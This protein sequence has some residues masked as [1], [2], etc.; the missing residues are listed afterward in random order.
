MLKPVQIFVEEDTL[1]W[2]AIQAIK[3]KTNRQKFLTI[4]I[5]SIKTYTHTGK[6][7]L[8]GDT[9]E[10][11]FTYNPPLKEMLKDILPSDKTK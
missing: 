5:E 3:R 6:F 8:N 9:L 4:C 11:I 2:A 7:P 10:E 1:E